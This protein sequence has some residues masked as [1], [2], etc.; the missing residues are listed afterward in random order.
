MASC[1]RGALAGTCSE[2]TGK[3]VAD[4][5]VFLASTCTKLGGT[6]VDAEC[7]NTSVIG[8]CT[9]PTS[10]VRNFYGT[11]SAAWD[12]E[13]ARSEC[14]GSLGGSLQASLML[15]KRPGVELASSRCVS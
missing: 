10:E 15:K 12:P 11:G 8:A 5:K 4:N 3:H 7:P 13:R 6:F 1:D 2:H 14:A 9:L